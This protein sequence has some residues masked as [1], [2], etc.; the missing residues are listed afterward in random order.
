M[1]VKALVWGR[2]KSGMKDMLLFSDIVSGSVQNIGIF[3]VA[4]NLM[5]K[6]GPLGVFE[7]ILAHVKDFFFAMSAQWILYQLGQFSSWACSAAQVSRVQ[8]LSP[9]AALHHGW[10]FL[11][12]GVLKG[13]LLAPSRTVSSILVTDSRV[14]TYLC[15]YLSNMGEV[16]SAS[17]SLAYKKWMRGNASTGAKFVW[18]LLVAGGGPQRAG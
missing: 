5:E 1:K 8:V 6:N 17:N 4:V 12:L 16:M 7:S 13:V 9:L 2:L 3:W 11:G 14:L 18:A 10:W 15:L